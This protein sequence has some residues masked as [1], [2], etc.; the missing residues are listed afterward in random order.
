MLENKK[1]TI[2]IFI[3]NI[4]ESC[5]AVIWRGIDE[6]ASQKGYTIVNYVGSS[7]DVHSLNSHFQSVTDFIKNN[8]SLDGLILFSGALLEYEDYDKINKFCQETCD[9]PIV[10]IAAKHDN[11]SNFIVDNT[12]GVIDLIMHLKEKHNRHK[13]AFIKGPENHG[14][15]EERFKAYK[16]ALEI[17]ELEY[18][19]ELVLPGH[20]SDESGREGVRALIK[21]NRDFDAIFAVDD[22]TA[23][24]VLRELKKIGINVPQKV[25]VVG[26]DNVENSEYVNPPLS[27]VEQ[28]LHMLG[29]KAVEHLVK[30]INGEEDL[31]DFTIPTV[32]T[33]RRSCGCIGDL[34]FLPNAEIRFQNKSQTISLSKA[35]EENVKKKIEKAFPAVD[36]DTIKEDLIERFTNCVKSTISEDALL[37]YIDSYLNHF[38]KYKDQYFAFQELF[39]LIAINIP[40]LFE[41]KYQSYANTILQ[42]VTIFVSK[43]LIR[44]TQAANNEFNEI[45]K[46]IRETSQ[47]LM[48]A[49]SYNEMSNV[50]LTDLP[51]LGI[52]EFYFFVYGTGVGKIIEKDNWI[53]PKQSRL[54]VGYNPSQKF[55]HTSE[56]ILIDTADV[57]IALKEEERKTLIF[58]PL[59]FEDEQLGFI[60][61]KSVPN[62]Y[63]FMYEELRLHLSSA[64]RS[65][66]TLQKV[67]QQNTELHLQKERANKLTKIA[68]ESNRI[69]SDFLA[70]MSHDIRTP[71]NGVIGISH[72]LLDTPLSKEQKNY[73][74]NILNSSKSLLS[75]INDILDFSKIEANKLEIENIS[76]NLKELLSEFEAITNFEAERKGIHFSWNLESNVP[77]NIKSDPNRIRQILTNLIGNALKFTNKGAVTL[78]CS[79]VKQINDNVE[80]MFSITDSG[81]GIAE[82]KI[83]KLFKSFTQVDSSTTRKYGGSGLGLTISKRLTELLGGEISASSKLG[84][85]S[86][87]NFTILAEIK[88]EHKINNSTNGIEPVKSDNLSKNCS[89]LIVEDNVVNQ[90][91]ATGLFKKFGY[92]VKV[93]NNGLEAVEKVKEGTFD[94]VFMDCQMPEMDGFEST[95][96]IRE[97]ENESNNIPIIA[98]TANAMGGDK[99][100]CLSSGM[101]DYLSKPID[102]VHLKEKLEKWA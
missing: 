59:Y 17:A 67:K 12:V 23:F 100:K 31:I 2:G 78:D 9:I 93:A 82:E 27:T 29:A 86:V 45:Q 97:L 96:K 37:S 28:P 38:A 94:L 58:M 65:F 25:S 71:M 39:T 8:K 74:E 77:V 54:I 52:E 7:E 22:E 20:F 63:E 102:P 64:L 5:Q 76:F 1:H 35:I 99:E 56:P 18:N 24:G 72:L 95:K 73:T 85:G 81:I 61:I 40:N 87:F 68:E 83:E 53:M 75:L 19:E 32:L 62:Y 60:L 34:S 26:F 21:E 36:S 41:K 49:L 15:A 101:D 33:I 4:H 14:E 30:R 3:E 89:I 16:K 90:V 13:I 88:N 50:I 79:L 48:A 46:Q 98:M 57:S 11:T 84:K 43:H 44:F 55:P 66:F 47:R 6:W 42:N 70:N 80:I 92:E 91:V 51:E 69:K 10:S